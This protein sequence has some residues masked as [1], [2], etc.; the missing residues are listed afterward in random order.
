MRNTRDKF[1]Y[2]GCRLLP[3]PGRTGPPASRILLAIAL[4][5]FAAAL[6]RAP[7]ARAAS[8][9]PYIDTLRH[10]MAN[11]EARLTALV[12]ERDLKQARMNELAD[13]IDALKEKQKESPSFLNRIRL[14]SL[15]SDSLE[16]SK[17][18]D[19]IELKI[20]ELETGVESKRDLILAEYDRELD[21]TF[22]KLKTEKDRKKIVALLR[23]YITL[24]NERNSLRAGP[25]APKELELL[26]VRPEP[27]DSARDL[28]EKADLVADFIG[29]LSALLADVEARMA[30]VKRE[31]ELNKEMNLFIEEGN[32][33][34]EGGIFQNSP[35][36]RILQDQP[37]GVPDLGP[38]DQK[39]QGEPGVKSPPAFREHSY[40][41]SQNASLKAQLARLESERRFILEVMDRL[42][43]RQSELR[44]KA[45][46]A[47][48]EKL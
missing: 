5:L 33:F 31:M 2:E 1:K 39:S 35:K 41:G 29:K 27:G 43:Q 47:V 24:R 6:F 42:K 37:S 11:F 21:T 34:E 4:A 26:D 20:R 12:K 7:A 45:A 38:E 9:T 18:L 23:K 10:E 17:V 48:K 22:P 13:Q 15:L 36:F 40:S 3:A 16:V 32:L 8:D 14:E 19:A 44:A 25:S 46:G 30:E 28:L